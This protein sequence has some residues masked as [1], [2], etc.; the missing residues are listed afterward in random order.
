MKI[1]ITSFQKSTNIIVD[2]YVKGISKYCEVVCAVDPFWDSNLIFDIIHIQWIEELFN[3]NSISEK[4][5]YDLEV[6]LIYW[7]NKTS[8]IIVTY[9]N[10]LPHR[11]KKDVFDEKLYNLF[12]RYTDGIIHLGEQSYEKMKNSQK[13]NN[14]KS[15][16]IQHPNYI[17][18]L[19]TTNATDA[20]KTLNFRKQDFIYL[21]FGTLRHKN[22]QEFLLK[23]FNKLKVKNKKLIIC[24]PYIEKASK[25]LII[26]ILRKA[27]KLFRSVLK[28]DERNGI[29]YINE[30]IA[31]NGLQNYINAS[32][33]FVLPRLNSLN[34]GVVYLAFSFKKVIIGPNIG[35]MKDVLEKNDNPIFDTFDF[36]TLTYEMEKVHKMDLNRIEDENFNYVI[37]ECSNEKIGEL[38]YNFYKSILNEF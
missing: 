3:W 4:D 20:R 28:S 15:T 25:N 26:R 18:I 13:L 10:E 1:L 24:K 6:R 22:E 30:R 23:A 32:N 19:N 38:H 14:I 2:N 16:I 31:N 7:H 27:N 11:D 34:S 5:I 12:F 35:N 29:I 33:V 9:H 17:H 21:C 36:N 37:N 8:K